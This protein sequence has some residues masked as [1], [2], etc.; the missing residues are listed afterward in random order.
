[1][2]RRAPRAMLETESRGERMAP[3]LPPD[4]EI[5]I[6]ALVL[7]LVEQREADDVE[8][9]AILIRAQ[10]ARCQSRHRIVPRDGLARGCEEE[11]AAGD[12]DAGDLPDQLMLVLGRQ[13]EHEPPAQHAV[14]RAIEEARLLDAFARHRRVWEIALEDLNER[15]SGIDAE[16]LQPFGYQRLGNRNPWTAPEVNNGGAFRQR[17]G[18]RSHGR[19]ADSG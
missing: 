2:T 8:L 16:D 1:M 9:P 18:P 4:I 6:P 11:T 10:R 17:S 3:N 13:Q 14:E 15:W 5:V 12:Q 19:H 7:E